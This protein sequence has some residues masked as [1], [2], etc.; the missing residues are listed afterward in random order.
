MIMLMLKSKLN[1][2]KLL[3]QQIYFQLK[4]DAQKIAN[5]KK[6]H[7]TNQEIFPYLFHK[8][9]PKINMN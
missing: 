2:K 8:K 9:E 7:K 1:L 5:S 6:Q 4:Q 3:L